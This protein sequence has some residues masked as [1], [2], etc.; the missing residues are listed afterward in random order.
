MRTNASFDSWDNC[1]SFW[2][3]AVDAEEETYQAV[4]EV[5]GRRHN[6]EE[7]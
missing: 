3:R 2:D 7:E 4:Q 5:T 1:L 6:R